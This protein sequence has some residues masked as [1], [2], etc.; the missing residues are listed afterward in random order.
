[1]NLADHLSPSNLPGKPIDANED[2][3]QASKQEGAKVEHGRASRNLTQE[4]D[5]HCKSLSSRIC[6]GITLPMKVT[7]AAKHILMNVDCSN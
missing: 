6:Q 7:I 5:D 2:D 3:Y 1:M 4:D